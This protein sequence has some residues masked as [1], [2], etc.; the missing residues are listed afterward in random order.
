MSDSRS[1]SPNESDYPTVYG[2]WTNQGGVGKTTLTFHL[3][4]TYAKLFPDKVVVAIDMCPQAN[5]S[6]TLL[7]SVG[8]GFRGGWNYKTHETVDLALQLYIV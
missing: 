7:T 6:N 4:T 2:L 3:A 5:L 8:L 1:H